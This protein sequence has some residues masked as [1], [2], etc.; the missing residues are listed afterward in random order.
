MVDDLWELP[1]EYKAEEVNR[2]YRVNTGQSPNDDDPL[3]P[4]SGSDFRSTPTAAQPG[5][6]NGG[7]AVAFL[8]GHQRDNGEARLSFSSSS[9]SSS[10]STSFA[11]RKPSFF[12]SIHWTLIKCFWR[13]ILAGSVLR[14]VA[15][16]FTVLQ[17]IILG[18]LIAHVALKPDE[19]GLV[20]DDEEES[21]RQFGYNN[22]STT[23]MR[24]TT[25][26]TSPADELPPTVAEWLWKGIF[27]AL[28]LTVVNALQVSV[29]QVYMWV[30]KWEGIFFQ[31]AII[32]VRKNFVI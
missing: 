23:T 7:M 24:T 8:N 26:D 30:S 6:Q 3:H 28:M 25:N 16:I 20:T 22:Q 10:S 9:S 18:W 31:T 27:Y 11:A 15:L 21:K 12:T 14:F 19:E 1:A 29:F 2:L 4:Q 13:R 5:E 17:P 32:Q